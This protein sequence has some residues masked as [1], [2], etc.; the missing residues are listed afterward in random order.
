MEIWCRF[1]QRFHGW[2][3]NFVGLWCA[4]NFQQVLMKNTSKPG[5]FETND[6]HHACSGPLSYT[7]Q[8]S[9]QVPWW[10]NTQCTKWFQQIKTMGLEEVLLLLTRTLRQTSMLIPNNTNETLLFSC[11]LKKCFIHHNEDP[12]FW[13]AQTR[14]WR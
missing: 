13:R 14:C 9:T 12:P 10:F 6:T 3:W 8:W 7:L 5:W 1:W 2:S 4:R 11:M